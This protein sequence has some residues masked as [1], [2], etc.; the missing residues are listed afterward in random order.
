MKENK[1]KTAVIATTIVAALVIS[2][3]IITIVTLSSIR[4]KAFD[5]T[6]RDIGETIIFG[7][8]DIDKDG[9]DKEEMEWII[10]DKEDDKILVVSKYAVAEK[11]Y[12]TNSAEIDWSDCSLRKWLND[13]FYNECFSQEDQEK[14][15]KSNLI[16]DDYSV[17]DP[18]TAEFKDGGSPTEDFVFALSK[19][20]AEE[21]L[22][23]LAKNRMKVP[24][25]C[26][27]SKEYNSPE[28]GWSWLRGPGTNTK[29]AA[30]FADGPKGNVFIGENGKG[31]G[32]QTVLVRPAIWISIK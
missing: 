17:R 29:S 11:S 13:D 26:Y 9:K 24:L 21:Y 32:D 10:L 28:Y 6:S 22:D 3:V 5:Y 16:N 2:G 25:K 8:Y 20:E 30:Y 1:K 4:K 15:I 27:I 7:E 19:T 18:N 12:H 23:I 31:V 14:I